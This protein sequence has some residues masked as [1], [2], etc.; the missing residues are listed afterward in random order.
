MEV[1]V[2]AAAIQYLRLPLDIP[3][4]Y[5]HGPD[6]F[7]KPGV[8][9]GRVLRLEHND[10]A[11][12]PGTERSIRLYIPVQYR[13]SEPAA[14]I[15]FQDGELYFDPSGDIRAGVVLDNL[16]DS[17]EIPVTI[18]VFVDPGAPGNRNTEYDAEDDRYSRFLLEEIIPL[19]RERVAITDDPEHWAICGGSSGGNCAF[20]VAW[21]RPDRF[22]R[23]ISFVG[24]FAQMAGGNPYPRLIRSMPT[25]PLRVF[26]Q[27]GSRD[28]N[29]N[30]PA[31]N[32][33]SENLQVAAA[34][35]ERGYD[36]RLVLGAGGHS[37]NHGGVLLPDALRWIWR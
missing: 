32:W 24:S 1:T 8:P 16:I 5:A 27:A 34:L 23:A 25:K 3:V 10:S 31:E 26:L 12:F 21:N 20:T 9:E 2:D 18:G 7:R 15:V 6:S 30:Q 11:I 4:E 36:N 37:T 22:R 17:G 13:E 28:L 14:L 29:W 35:A 19:V 33:Y